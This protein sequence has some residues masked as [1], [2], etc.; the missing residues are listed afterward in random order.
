MKPTFGEL[1]PQLRPLFEDVEFVAAHNASFDEGVLRACCAG[2]SIRQPEAPFRCTMR[3]ARQVWGIYPTRLPDVC[4]RLGIP[5][6]HHEALS[7]T[8]ACASIMVAA[9]QMEG[10]RRRSPQT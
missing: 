2:A 9:L 3:L 1:W 7:D 8:I 6:N 5:L 10:G 4:H